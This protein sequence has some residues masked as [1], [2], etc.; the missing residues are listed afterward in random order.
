M[1]GMGQTV[2]RGWARGAATVRG[3]I[4]SRISACTAACRVWPDGR[5]RARAGAI[6]WA[7]ASVTGQNQRWGRMP[8]LLRLRAAGQPR[9]AGRRRFR[10]SIDARWDGIFSDW[11]MNLVVEERDEAILIYAANIA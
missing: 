9:E 4:R 3:A 2:V 6:S 10:C 11:P 7:P 1:L 8:R 5:R